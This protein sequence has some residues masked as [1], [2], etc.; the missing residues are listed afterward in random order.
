VLKKASLYA[1]V[2][3]FL[4]ASAYAQFWPLPSYTTP[5]TPVPCSQCQDTAL[6]MPTPGWHDPVIAYVG[7]FVSSEYVADFQ[8]TYRTARAGGIVFSPDGSRLAVRLG[9]GVATYD[10]AT[11]LS[12]LSAHE[13]M[14]SAGELGVTSCGARFCG[15]V[16][17]FLNFE[18]YF[19]A[20]ASGANWSIALSDGQDRLGLF[21]MDDRGLLYIGY[22]QFAWG[23]AS[24]L[25]TTLAAGK[26]MSSWQDKYAFQNWAPVNAA[27][28]VKDGNDYYALSY[29]PTLIKDPNIPGKYINTSNI[30]HLYKAVSYG[31]VTELTP[32]NTSIKSLARLGSR[33][34]ILTA[35]LTSQLSIYDNHALVTG[36]NPITSLPI[37]GFSQLV[38]DGTYWWASLY[39]SGV[40]KLVRIS[41]D[42]TYVTF[43][44]TAGGS[45]SLTYG[46][47]YLTAVT[48]D[49]AGQ[50]IH[51]YKVTS[52]VPVE[53][54]QPL[55]VS[56][57]YR[58]QSGFAPI[59]PHMSLKSANTVVSGGK[60]YLIVSADGLGDVY[61]LRTDDMVNVAINGTNGPWNANAPAKGLSDIFYGDTV[62]MNASLSSNALGGAL[63]W[64]FGAPH[65]PANTQ[66]GTFGAAITHQYTGLSKT[67]VVSPVT[68]TVTNSANGVTGTAQVTLKTG[69]ARVQYG[70]AGG[71][72]YLAGSGKPVMMDDSFVDASDG[73]TTGHY[74]EWRVGPDAATITSPTFIPQLTDPLTA[75]SVGGCGQHTLSMTAHYG[76]SAYSA[77]N[78]D[79]PVTLA[80]PFTYNAVAFAPGV[81]VSY[82]AVSGN[83][84]FFSTS[85]A[86]AAL[87]GRTI[88]Y[89]WAV[90][91]SDGSAVTAIPTQSGTA[92]S[93][94][95]IP[96]YLVSKTAF[97]QPGYKG[98]LTLT[99]S[100]VDP[101]S[102]TGAPLA[103]LSATSSA[104]VT[105]DA[106]LQSSCSSG[107]CTYTIISP[108]NVM[109][110]DAW[111]F[112]WTA[113]GGDPASGAASSLTTSY[114]TAGT[115]PVSVVVTNKTGLSKTVTTSTTITTPASKCPTFTTSNSGITYVGTAAGSNCVDG[116]TCQ[117]SEPIVFSVGFFQINP[118]QTCLGALTYQWLVDGSAQGV[119]PTLNTSLA[120]GSHIVAVTLKAGS[121]TINL[122]RSITI[123]TPPPPPPT[124]GTISN[125]NVTLGY[126]GTTS[127]CH[128]GGTC[129]VN[130]TITVDATLWNVQAGSCSTS[131]SWSY[132]GAAGVLGGTEVTHS[133]STPGAHTISVTVTLNGTRGTA[134]TNVIVAGGPVCPVITQG[135]NATINYVGA[136]SGCTNSNA[137]VQCST[138]ETIAFSVRYSNYT[139]SCGPHH[140]TWK[141]DGWPVGGDAD[142][143][144]VASLTS[145]P[146]TVTVAV[147]NGN[148]PVTLSQTVN[149]SNPVKP[150]Y[151]FDFT[152][153]PLAAPA[154]SYT[155]TVVVTP[156]SPTKPTQWKW[157][158]GDGII[159][160]YNAGATQ[161]HTFPDDKAYTVTVSATDGTGGIVSH[162]VEP[163]APPTKRRGVRH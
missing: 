127:T 112:A 116:A 48:G 47:G 163:P 140:Y 21:D 88:S 62:K 14:V 83:E 153:V 35:S 160:P 13:P 33:S 120:S 37:Y 75:V 55:S 51:I 103:P 113:T 132:D 142:N 60:L 15:P 146:H 87:T 53:Q 40:M 2:L 129:G 138:S 114:Y 72:K 5:D 98:S 78:V 84:E 1:V 157:D 4:S 39:D 11:F 82:N 57:Y 158:F 151:T 79:F 45:A 145:G 70:P 149:V 107:I 121:Q 81:D 135:Q 162:T 134:T 111:T 93:F 73:D 139:P 30:T 64:N 94:D 85:R 56:A 71:T 119:G 43:P 141:V 27:F 101:C 105:P 44:T 106:Q 104:L 144:S 52:G 124:C 76:Y 58:N 23:V 91:N 59:A 38:S 117:P 68:V 66:P 156:D 77:S 147:D 130:E 65:D 63:T 110:S 97:T 125:Q 92:T 133:F 29:G 7:R 69:T 28:W 100:G 24:D 99:V 9:Q 150:N 95:T 3:A 32:V 118:D 49:T 128:D 152:I 50:N 31:N 34:A 123:G 19:Y 18:R 86:S 154:N 122:T 17:T 159:P 74:T 161:T 41:P 109:T 42:G 126:A 36:G 137:D 89:T 46:S 12:R 80:A 155:F 10:T 102:Q 148:G 115:F 143:T 16:E 131:Y 61:Q 6:N 54:P 25:P 8:Q 22:D 108:S 26:L 20:Q 136:A 67:D 96:R 90:V